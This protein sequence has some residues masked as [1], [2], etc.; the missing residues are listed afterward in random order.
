[1]ARLADYVALARP[2]HWTK[3][4][5]VL[6]PLPHALA[7]GGSFDLLPKAAGLAG[8]SNVTSAVYV[9]ND[10]RD[11]PRDRAHPTKR[12]R[13]V[14]AGKITP[15]AG[16]TFGLLLLALGLTLCW[17]S[18]LPMVLD[19]TLTYVGIN[20]LYSYRGRSI[21]VIDVFLLASGF[22]IRVILGC[23]LVHSI[24]SL[25]LLLC[26]ST[27]A[28][29][30]TFAKRRNDL[31]T[32]VDGDHR[33]SLD[34]Y[35]VTFLEQAMAITATLALMA[36][37]SFCMESPVLVEGR[38]FASLPFVAFGVLEYLRRVRIAGDGGSPVDLLL[39]SRALQA[40]GIGWMLATIWSLG[41]L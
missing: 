32:G 15:R 23:A 29:F 21:P 37:A 12:E 14:A 11:A 36:Y 16:A 22:V 33:A 31:L 1:M 39:G 10:C 9:F 24:A 4:V 40:C 13:P 7:G 25:W 27:L 2:R 20:A 17:S 8:F 41:W 30:M 38:Q 19:L 6:M 26:S 18:G 35:D 34:G 3:N 28:L 5:F